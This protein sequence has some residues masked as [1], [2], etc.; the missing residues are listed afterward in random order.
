[1]AKDEAKPI[2]W[3]RLTFIEGEPNVEIEFVWSDKPK[4]KGPGW[5]PMH[6]ERFQKWFLELNRP[7]KAT[8]NDDPF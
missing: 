7:K 1:M 4:P 6:E 3:A 5:I 8:E 2:A